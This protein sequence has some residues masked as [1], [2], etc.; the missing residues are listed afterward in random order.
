MSGY[1]QRSEDEHAP[2]PW[3]VVHL[4]LHLEPNLFPY[5]RARPFL[6]PV[7]VLGWEKW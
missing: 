4:H 5:H 1:W 2:E 3:Y 6:V 7:H